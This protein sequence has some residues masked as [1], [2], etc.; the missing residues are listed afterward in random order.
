M[1]K[2]TKIIISIF[3]I[4]IFL[5]FIILWGMNEINKYHIYNCTIRDIKDTEI[6]AED[7]QRL[8]PFSLVKRS[9][10]ENPEYWGPIVKK[11]GEE[12]I[13]EK[14]IIRTKGI[15]I[16]DA[17]GKEISINDL[18][19]GDSLYVVKKDGYEIDYLDHSLQNVILI[20]VLEKE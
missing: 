13:Y 9:Y 4:I 12:Y 19:L 10:A 6:Y 7:K 15:K 14:Y 16:K 18:K 17:K 5:I 2:K 8:I 3:V 1:K 11:N 20:K